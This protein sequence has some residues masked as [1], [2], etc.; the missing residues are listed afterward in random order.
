MRVD[1]SR[2]AGIFPVIR[3]DA[4]MHYIVAGGTGGKYRFEKYDK[5]ALAYDGCL[6]QS[7]Y[8]AAAQRHQGGAG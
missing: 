8:L 5:I 3:S 4:G 1:T 2:C 7:V 6:A